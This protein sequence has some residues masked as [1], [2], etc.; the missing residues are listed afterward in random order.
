VI[1]VDTSVWVDHLRRGNATLAKKLESGD[2]ACHPF[3]VGELSLG[4]LEHRDEVLNLLSELPMASVVP[5]EDVL[6]LV[7][8]RDL[9]GRGIGWIDVHLIASAQVDRLRLWTLDRRLAAA[10]RGV[11][12][13]VD[14]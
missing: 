5:H 4:S 14:Q 8:R 9:A 11:K 10:A 1:L 6:A 2:V 12:V 7:G 3:V 13:L